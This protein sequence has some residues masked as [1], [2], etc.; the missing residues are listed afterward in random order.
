[1]SITN[2]A[3]EKTYTNVLAGN[4]ISV[5][6]PADT[7][8]ELFVYYGATRLAAVYGTDYAI[9][10]A[11]DFTSFTLTPTAS[12]ITKI[13]VAGQ[14]NV[15]YVDRVLPYTSDLVATDGFFKDKLIHAIDRVIMRFQQVVSYLKTGANH[16]ITI[17]TSAPSGGE[18]GDIWLKVP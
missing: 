1:M 18:D 15:I 14:G 3:V 4:P 7:V 12:L 16:N 9:A 11:A 10:F 8:A 13:G 2:T 17:S 5:A 6:M